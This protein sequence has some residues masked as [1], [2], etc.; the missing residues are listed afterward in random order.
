MKQKR[1]FV[2]A[3]LILC[4]IAT[5]F[6]AKTSIQIIFYTEKLTIAYDTELL[7]AVCS[8]VDEKNMSGFYRQL[9][10]K[11]YRILLNDLLQKKEQL[12][13]NDWLFYQLLQ[14]SIAEIFQKKSRLERDLLV[15]FFL[16]QSGFDTRLAY[17][18]QRAH[19]YV[20]TTDEVFEMS[21]IQDGERAYVNLTNSMAAQ[22]NKQQPLYLLLFV[23]KPQGKAFSFQLASLPKLASVPQRQKLQFNYRRQSIALE[24]TYDKTPVDIMAEYPLI[25]EQAYLEIPMSET[26]STSLI[27]QLQDLI[28]SK[29]TLQALELLL[30]FTRSAF[31]YKEDREAF[32][33]NKPM[34]VEELFFYAYSDCEDRTA[35][36]YTLVKKLLD[37]PMIIVAFPDHLTV[38][39]AI[40]A[41]LTGVTIEHD[42]RRYYICDPTGPVNSSEVGVFPKEY[43]NSPFEIIHQ[44][45]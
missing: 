12:Q 31:N 30:A 27:P 37:L 11:D 13:L 25:A 42:N 45:K 26:L 21:M 5:L 14:Q 1:Y 44:Y 6:A 29:T 16:S 15:W 18:Q 35:L 10:R 7:N 8:T 32:G 34:I 43:E 4:H 23:A 40:D 20:H 38:A 33:K 41:A 22:P 36:F 19:L 17:L 2:L 39:V 24:I 28:S 3:A 9:E